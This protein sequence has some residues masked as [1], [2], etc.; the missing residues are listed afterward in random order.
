MKNLYKAY[1]RI[2]VNHEERT[3]RLYGQLDKLL[4]ISNSIESD[5]L[6]QL[7]PTV[8]LSVKWRFDLLTKTMESPFEIEH[9]IQYWTNVLQA[10]DTLGDCGWYEKDGTHKKVDPWD[11][12]ADG[13][14]LG[15]TTT[16]KGENFEISKQIAKDRLE[17]IYEKLGGKS[18][19]SGKSILDSGCGPGRYVDELRQLNPEHIVALDQ[20]QR[21][22]DVLNERFKDDKR[23]QVIKGTC[24]DLSQFDD[25]SFDVV[26]SNGV[27]HHTQSDLRTM[28]MDHARVLKPGGAMF[29]MLIGKSGLELKLWEF[30]RAFLNDIPMNKIIETFGSKISPL[31]LQGIVDHMYGEYQET[32]R[33]V[34]EEWCEGVFSKIDPV[35]GIAGLDVTPEIY[36]DDQYFKARFGCGHLRYVLTK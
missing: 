20:G 27:I 31:R 14:D 24:E 11:R 23:V 4:E 2:N 30:L 25:N 3:K 34:F 8:A 9:D 32:D 22:I 6:R 19:F 10:L 35:A 21:L 13:F 1:D 5:L 7:K 29:I 15:W 12:T 26:F 16:T 28:F 17:Q 33:T 36:H 18:Y